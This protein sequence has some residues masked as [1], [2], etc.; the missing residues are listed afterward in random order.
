[1]HLILSLA[2]GWMRR[3]QQAARGSA[4]WI[5]LG[6][7]GTVL[8]LPVGIG[9]L[10][11]WAL[12]WSIGYLQH[13]GVLSSALAV[14]LRT[15][16]AGRWIALA[17][18]PLG[19]ALFFAFH[20]SPTLEPIAGVGALLLGAFWLVLALGLRDRI[21]P[22]LET[23]RASGPWSLDLG[24]RSLTIYLWHMVAVYAVIELG[25]PGNGSP[26]G[27]SSGCAAGDGPRSGAVR[28]GRGPGGPTS[29]PSSGPD[30]RR[31]RPAPGRTAVAEWPAGRTHPAS[32][33][34]AE[35]TP[36]AGPEPAQRVP[37]IRSPASPRPGTM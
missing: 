22:H 15:R 20:E 9:G 36:A 19:F 5:A 32:L 26:C 31:P 34:R 30:S 24:A 21:E 4:Y 27:A 17:T 13:D 37:K 2:G 18:G 11:F 25:L 29:A 6:I 10:L 7:L 33:Q 8:L 28:M 23:E 35:L 16:D 14:P 3:M 12:C 1:M